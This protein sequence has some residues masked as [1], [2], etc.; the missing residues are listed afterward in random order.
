[1]GEVVF[2][3]DTVLSPDRLVKAERMAVPART[4]R[5]VWLTINVP[6]DAAPGKYKG[7]LTASCDGKS[8]SVPF[9]IEVSKR[10]LPE[11]RDWKFHLDLWQN[12]Y[13]VARYFNVPLWSKEH[14]DTMR[15]I[16]EYL[17]SAGQKV[18]TASIRAQAL[19]DNARTKTMGKML[20]ISS[21]FF[22]INRSNLAK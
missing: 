11:P 21:M 15:P 7:S 9:T 16:M 4:V 18:I 6:R 13:A 2:K 5:P 14:F 12:P 22:L 20:F 10:V 3:G 17:A 1:M 19:H 8:L